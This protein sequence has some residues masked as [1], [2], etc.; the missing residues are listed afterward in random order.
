MSTKLPTMSDVDQQQFVV[1]ARLALATIFLH[2]AFSG[3][4]PVRAD[5][6]DGL[7]VAA[8]DIADKLL[9]HQGLTEGDAP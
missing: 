8:T 5:Q 1:I 2:A 6:F 3:A 9:A 7:V 4:R